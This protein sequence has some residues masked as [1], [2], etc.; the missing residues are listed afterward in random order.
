MWQAI[1]TPEFLDMVKTCA[2]WAIAFLV[3]WGITMVAGLHSNMPLKTKE[4]L[5]HLR[6]LAMDLA[7]QYGEGKEAPDAEVV[8]KTLRLIMKRQRNASKL[9]DVYLYDHGE[10]TEITSAKAKLGKI[11]TYCRHAVSALSGKK[12]EGVRNQAV[13]IEKAAKEAQD[14]LDIVIAKNEQ[15]KLMKI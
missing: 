13:L 9:L 2:G 12:P 15:E 7:D 11:N 10:S 1:S 6:K 3:V 8:V 5:D 14:L 4:R